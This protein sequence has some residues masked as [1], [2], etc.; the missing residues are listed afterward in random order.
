MGSGVCHRGPR[1]GE[2]HVRAAAPAVRWHRGSGPG[3]AQDLHHQRCLRG[4]HYQPAGLPRPDPLSA[5]REDGQRRGEA[6]DSGTRVPLII[7]AFC[8]TCVFFLTDYPSTRTVGALI[9]YTL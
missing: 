2:G 3:P 7:T 8:L 4:G 6:H 5:E 1:A 9:N